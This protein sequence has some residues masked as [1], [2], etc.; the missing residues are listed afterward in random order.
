MMVDRVTKVYINGRLVDRAEA[1]VSVFD[2]GFLYGDGIFEGIRVYGGR[3]FK[4]KEHLDRLYQ[5]AKAIL[6][7]I[8]LTPA[9]MEQAVIDTVRAN[10]LDNAYIRLVVS[11]G[12]GDLGLDPLRC[13]QPTVIIIVEEISL[14]PQDVYLNG[15]ELASVVVRRPAPDALNPA[16]KTLNYLNN[17]LAKIEANQRGLVEVLML[18][19]EGWVVEAT[20]D[21]V[22]LVKA[23]ELLTPPTYV[24]ILNGITRQVVMV[25]AEAAGYRVREVNFTLFDV[26]NADEV[27]L[28][29]TAAEMVPVARCDGRVIGSGRP[30]R[31][32]KDLM[33]RFRVYARSEGVSVHGSETIQA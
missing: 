3:V 7:S 21:N 19:H 22:F 27:F 4:L 31:I 11:R 15:L 25:L 12:P 9:A 26:Y 28:T 16:M 1:T 32:T 10:G 20:A 33:E 23:G 2:H 5:S 17:I 18:N 14:Y 8:P 13:S 24:G 6:L 29:G 30:G